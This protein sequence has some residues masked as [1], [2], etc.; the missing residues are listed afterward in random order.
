[1]NPI[2]EKI[3]YVL[4][5]VASSVVLGVMSALWRGYK[6]DIK[7]L[8]GQLVELRQIPLMNVRLGQVEHIVGDLSKHMQSID[9]M[10]IELETMEKNVSKLASIV[11]QLSTAVAL[12]Q[13]DMQSRREMPAV[14]DPAREHYNPR[15]P[16]PPRIPREDK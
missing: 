6:A 10:E 15:I 1:V 7:E 16:G 14:R 5:T 13:R 11:P 12:L 4:L 3:I 2:V 9:K 8:Q